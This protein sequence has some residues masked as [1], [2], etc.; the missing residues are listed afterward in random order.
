VTC[1]FGIVAALALSTEIASA[2]SI[3]NYQ[4]TAAGCFDCTTAGPFADQPTVTSYA[5]DGAT[6]SG[7]TNASGSAAVTL[8]T[9][10]RDNENYSQSA[11][12]NDF[13]L[14]VTFLIPVGVSGGA[15][16]FVA[17]IIGVQGQPGTLDFD[18]NFR[19]YSF[20][21]VSGTG[22]FDFQVNDIIDLNKNHTDNLTGNI[23][24]AV[25]TPNDTGDPGTTGTGGAVP[26]PGSLLL[27]GSGLVVSARH[28]RRRRASK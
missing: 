15:D 5:F 21:N 25:F 2:T 17:T 19:T 1:S 22:T 13:V 3:L 18:N 20:T 23:R 7:T 9:L 24:N 14:Q 28:L 11:T 27:L 12:G 10:T 8:G 6:T 16:E 26:E 4:V